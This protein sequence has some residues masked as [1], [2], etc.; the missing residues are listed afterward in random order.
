MTCARRGASRT[1]AQAVDDDERR[2]LAAR[3]R[4]TR[5][6]ADEVLLEHLR[7]VAD[8]D[9]CYTDLRLAEAQAA[10][11]IENE[12]QQFG[13]AVPASDQPSPATVISIS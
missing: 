6:F 11:S 1:R 8:S 7:E 9:Y 2:E 3:V 5:R 13:R 4:E 10:S 12:R